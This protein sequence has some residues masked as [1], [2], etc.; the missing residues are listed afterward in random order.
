MAGTGLDIESNTEHVVLII[1]GFLVS[2]L[3]GTLLHIEEE[4]AGRY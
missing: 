4:E 3:V 1:E 2:Q